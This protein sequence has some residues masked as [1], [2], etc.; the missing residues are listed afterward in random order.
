MTDQIEPGASTT[1]EGSPL[2]PTTL[3]GTR[4]SRRIQIAVT[5][6]GVLLSATAAIS[7]IVG[8]QIQYRQMRAVEGIAHRCYRP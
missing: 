6:G 7:A 4:S 3:P 8:Q 1:Q 2:I 5:I